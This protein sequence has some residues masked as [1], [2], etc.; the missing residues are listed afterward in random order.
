MEE[1]GKEETDVGGEQV[2]GI[3][4]Q[5]SSFWKTSRKVWNR[6]QSLLE[7]RWSQENIPEAFCSAFRGLCWILCE[8]LQ[9]T[10]GAPEHKIMREARIDIDS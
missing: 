9:T 8:G 4:F 7:S 2:S 3:T 10:I 5:S 1:N 6:V